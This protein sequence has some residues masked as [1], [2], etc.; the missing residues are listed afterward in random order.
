MIL[1]NIEH[2]PSPFL[3]HPSISLCR[4]QSF[5]GIEKGSAWSRPNG[6]SFIIVSRGPV[7]RGQK[8]LR[9][10]GWSFVEEQ[11]FGYGKSDARGDRGGL[12]HL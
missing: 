7:R 2:H 5:K 12:S 8:I 3:C 9:L 6:R 1:N 4:W 10:D 11:G